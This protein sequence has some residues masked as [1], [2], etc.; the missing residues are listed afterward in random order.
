MSDDSLDEILPTPEELDEARDARIRGLV[1]DC[2][3][4]IA[5][6]LRNSYS[7]EPHTQVNLSTPLQTYPKLMPDVI[8][9][10]DTRCRKRGWV[11]TRNSTN[12]TL[13][14]VSRNNLGQ[15]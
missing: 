8:G 4:I 5:S 13:F 2:L 15:G 3:V 1:K 14:T 12:A 7:V 10:V 9:E 6:E 11:L